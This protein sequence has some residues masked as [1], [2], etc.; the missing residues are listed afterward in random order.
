MPK[1][2]DTKLKTIQNLFSNGQETVL[3]NDGFF[4]IPE[5][6]RAYN[7]KANEQCDKLWQD[8]ESFIDNSQNKSYF[9]GTIIINNE[10][11]KLYLI[12]GQQRVTTFLIL[13][14]AILMK[15]NDILDG[16]INDEDS[17]KLKQA[18]EQR[19][20]EI[21][22]CLYAID[23]DDVYL[24]TEGDKKYSDLNIKYSNE[25]INEQ[26]KNDLKAILQGQDYDEI[27][28]NVIKFKNK[29]KISKKYT[30]FYNNF[31]YF[32][33]K[34]KDMG[35]DRLNKF[36]KDL[37]TKCQVIVVISYQTDESIEI[38]NSLNSTGMPLADA[39]I[40]SA[41]LYKN[42]EDD[43][44]DFNEKWGGIIAE[45]ND[46]SAKKIATIDDI[47]NQYMYIERAKNNEKDTT[48]PGVRRYFMDIHKE[49]L[50]TPETFIEDLRFLI[51]IWSDSNSNEE[52]EEKDV[53]TVRNIRNVKQ[54]LLKNNNNF[55]FYYATYLYLHREDS[56]SD[57]LSFSEELLKLFSILSI[58]EISYSS[59]LF[60]QFLINLNMKMGQ[61]LSCKN[62]AESI[63]EHNS[64]N[65]D[66][67][68]IEQALTNSYAENGIVYL[69]EYLFA[70]ENDAELNLMTNDIEIEHIM[71][72][73]GKNITAIREDA[74]MDEEE[75]A[76][77]ADKL[78][79]KILL[80]QN[81]N[82]SVSND[83]FRVKK[84]TSVKEK[85]G[86]RDSLF[87]IAQSLT[88]Y[89]SDTWTKNDIDI[90]TKKAAERIVKFIFG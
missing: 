88:K 7:W 17:K 43:K 74:G 36:A 65:F 22:R 12:D 26:Y 1:N 24:V 23:V 44:K 59:S 18:L 67:E 63:S 39:D 28:G 31:L 85:R 53:Q 21:I 80:E 8:I 77:Y 13:L 66:R 56:Y 32:K 40:I 5:Y 46:L 70:K 50:N 11:D 62:I 81:I 86:Y 79:N 16:F 6:Q 83:W 75:F 4:S 89:K 72:A 19:R 45:T 35:A 71:P 33:D 3:G 2:I 73:S 54:I 58:K 78:G 15:I 84:Q 55:K 64:D 61:G 30:N 47:L 14:K 48:L 90:A 27:E 49:L 42:F 82:G 29:R 60:K 10:Q 41:I 76:A 51:N 68:D 37:L 20:T 9:F 25:S 87:P 52:I 38:F 57:K 69:N 34:F